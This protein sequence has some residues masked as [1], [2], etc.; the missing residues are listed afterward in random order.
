M[1]RYA[2]R[3]VLVQVIKEERGNKGVS[4]TTYL[5]LAGRYCV[6]MPNSPKDGGISRKIASQEDRRRLKSIYTELKLAAGMS[7]IIRTAGMDR[8]RAEIKRDYDYLVKLWNRIRED[9]LNLMLPSLIY[10]EKLVT[11]SSAPSAINIRAISTS[12]SSKVR[13][14]TRQPR[15]S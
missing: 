13:T 1:I 11:S 12:S 15:N 4:L 5:S 3:I 2:A 10:E 7:V 6:L 8:T 14:G 9:T